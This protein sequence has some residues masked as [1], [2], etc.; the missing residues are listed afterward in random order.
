MPEALAPT[1]GGNSTDASWSLR[2]GVRPAGDMMCEEVSVMRGDPSSPGRC[3][4][5]KGRAWAEPGSEPSEQVQEESGQWLGFW[6]REEGPLVLQPRR[7]LIPPSPTRCKG[8]GAWASGL[9]PP[10]GQGVEKPQGRGNR[11]DSRDGLRLPTQRWVL[12]PCCLHPGP[13]A[14]LKAV[15]ALHAASGRCREGPVTRHRKARSDLSQ[16]RLLLQEEGW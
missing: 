6:S 12:G 14:G 2:L 11:E 10:H 13:A 8:W 3:E 7:T 4:A 1:L 9:S 15:R 5:W 16:G